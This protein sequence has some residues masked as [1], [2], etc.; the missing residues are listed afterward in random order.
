MFSIEVLFYIRFSALPK[1][2]YI[3]LTFSDPPQWTSE[4]G[5]EAFEL[6]CTTEP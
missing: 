2:V 3:S 5:N 6:Q 1:A 4:P